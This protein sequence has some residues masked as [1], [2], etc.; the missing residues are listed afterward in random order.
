MRCLHVVQFDPLLPPPLPDEAAETLA[1]EALERCLADAGLEP[2]TVEPRVRIGDAAREIAYEAAEW[3]ADLLVVGTHART[4]PEE[5]PV[6]RV[7]IGTVRGAAC[8]VLAIPACAP[9]PAEGAHAAAA[10]F[11]AAVALPA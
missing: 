6:G 3:D 7:A 11:T 9:A 4:G 2:D 1:R 10:G 5:H 8:N